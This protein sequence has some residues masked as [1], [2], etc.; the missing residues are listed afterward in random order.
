MI[1]ERIKILPF[2]IERIMECEIVKKVNEHGRAYIKGY[3]FLAF[4]LLAT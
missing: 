1:A 2:Q 3:I 4:D